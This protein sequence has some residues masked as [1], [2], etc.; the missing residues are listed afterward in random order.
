MPLEE[1][2]ECRIFEGLCFLADVCC[3]WTRWLPKCTGIPQPTSCLS[4]P[5]LLTP[6]EGAKHS[7]VLSEAL[8]NAGQ[9][10]DGVIKPSP[11]WR[12]KGHLSELAQRLHSTFLF[13]IQCTSVLEALLVLGMGAVCLPGIRFSV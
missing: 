12:S 1:V 9:S 11:S 2:W 13:V 4:V 10:R 7:Q 8:G 6:H 5:N 3:S